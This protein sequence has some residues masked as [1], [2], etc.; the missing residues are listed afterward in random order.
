MVEVGVNRGAPQFVQERGT[1]GS[2][3][4]NCR[5]G[6]GGSAFDYRVVVTRKRA[7]KVRNGIE[8]NV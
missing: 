3:V 6:P 4:L 1:G 7:L 8:K 2:S 5:V